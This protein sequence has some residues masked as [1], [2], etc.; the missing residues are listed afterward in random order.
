MQK[1]PIQSNGTGRTK[2]SH[3]QPQQKKN[4]IELPL[5]RHLVAR[6]AKIIAIAAYPVDSELRE[7]GPAHK[8]SQAMLAWMFRAAKANGKIDRLPDCVA[9]LK[10]QQMKNRFSAGIG[11]L[12]YRIVSY[13]TMLDA[14]LIA[15]EKDHLADGVI[16]GFTVRYSEDFDRVQI[17]FQPHTESILPAMWKSA[18]GRA[19]PQ[20]EKATEFPT[21]APGS[22][23]SSLKAAV[24][25]HRKAFKSGSRDPDLFYINVYNRYLKIL[26]PVF[27]I[28]S[29]LEEAMREVV[30]ENQKRAK[31]PVQSLLLQ[32]KWAEGAPEQIRKRI[33]SAIQ[34]MR[35]LGIE[36]SSSRLIHL[37]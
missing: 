6:A 28:I 32:P 4:K 14:L 9:A 31:S 20:T 35:R 25:R 10:V 23:S 37:K 21:G 27:P 7:G 13:R 3:N 26:F 30:M 11:R 12:H 22:A 36:M 1:R 15:T 2:K 34:F 16:P 33:P 17:Q 8:F 19:M 24:L 18:R 5:P 29:V